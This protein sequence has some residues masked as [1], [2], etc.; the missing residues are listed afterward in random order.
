[1]DIAAYGAF[2]G[3][4]GLFLHLLNRFVKGNGIQQELRVLFRETR[5]SGK[6]FHQRRQHFV[7]VIALGQHITRFPDQVLRHDAIGFGNRLRQ[8]SWKTH[9]RLLLLRF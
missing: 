9:G 2:P 5:S 8:C 1:M 6:L 7:R 4:H 3:F